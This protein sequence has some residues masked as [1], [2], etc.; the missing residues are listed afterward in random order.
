MFKSN[1]FARGGFVKRPL[2]RFTIFLACALAAALGFANSL[3]IPNE[4][5]LPGDSSWE[6]TNPAFNSE[7]EG[8]ASDV[9]VQAN[10][11]IKFFIS[12]DDPQATVSIYRVG[13]YGGVGGRKL[14]GP[15]T[16]N[17][18]RQSH[19]AAD[20][21]TGYLDAGWT[22][23]L[24]VWVPSR[25]AGTL[26]AWTSGFYL[27][28]VTGTTSGYQC[29][30]PFVVREPNRNSDLLFNSGVLTYAAY[31]FWGGSCF[32]SNP[33]ATR[34][35]LNRPYQRS[36]GAGDFLNWEIQMVRFLE[37]EGYDVTYETDIDL[38]HG[39]NYWSTHK[40]LLFVG[41]DE[42]WTYEMRQNV[43]NAR[44]W[45]QSIGNFAAN[46]CYWQVRLEPDAA[47]NAD[48]TIVCYKYDADTLD[49]YAAIQDPVHQSRITTMWRDPVLNR[50]EGAL[51][52]TEY[53]GDSFYGDITVT[54]ASHWVFKNSGLTNG[55]V[56][57]GLLGY[58]VDGVDTSTPSGATVLSSSTTPFGQSSMA[59][60][61]STAQGTV[62]STG[63]MQWSWGLDSY[64]T[65]WLWPQPNYVSPAA[66][67]I[68]RNVL[69]KFI[70]KKTP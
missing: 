13:W 49:P 40:A 21:S 53:I 31:D 22:A 43:E 1:R 24:M 27:A 39:R 32:Y 66:Q 10:N 41:H 65:A 45:T 17:T 48:R 34:I 5:A 36:Y 38:H 30:I 54:N 69:Y 20:P 11:A 68:T 2:L 56:L 59:I 58:E 6:L 8:Y 16:V 35:S 61:T 63:S 33:R 62:F 25:T 50:P 47:G 37:R 64:G 70:T 18:T 44:L 26:K 67:Q 51:F 23:N 60:Y 15:V 19:P 12:T 29:Y 7:I 9:S 55:S 4:N 57:T 42:Y 3:T 28:K 46:T 14:Y 52:G